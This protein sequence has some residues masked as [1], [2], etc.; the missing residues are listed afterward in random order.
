[1]GKSKI[2]NMWIVVAV[3]FFG[4]LTLLPY[5]QS[6]NRANIVFEAIYEDGSK[7]QMAPAKIYTLAVMPLGILSYE[8]KPISAFRAYLELTITATGGSSDIVPVTFTGA[9]SRDGSQKETIGPISQ[10]ISGISKGVVVHLFN[11][12]G[13]YLEATKAETYQYFGGTP[14][15]PPVSGSYS[16]TF[17]YSGTGTYGLTQTKNFAISAP[18]SFTWA[19]ETLTIV[20]NWQAA[21]IT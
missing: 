5:L 3:A 19:G 1:M 18:V 10:D 9:I 4:A 2:G 13:R 6:Q 21:P 17:S 8:G 16:L 12:E 15:K 20:A 14:D 11:T 7:L